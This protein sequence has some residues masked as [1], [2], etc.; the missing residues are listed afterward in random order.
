MVLE[1]STFPES[2]VKGK[3]LL[4]PGCSRSLVDNFA[5]D[6]IIQTLAF[7]SVA[8]LNSNWVEPLVQPQVFPSSDNACEGVT[9]SMELY[10]DA[11][12]EIAVIQIRSNVISRPALAEEIFQFASKFEVSKI[13]IVGSADGCFM[14]GTSLEQDSRLRTT[15]ESDQSI[16]RIDPIDV[17]S[18]GILKSLT[19]KNSNQLAVYSILML[20]SGLGFQETIDRSESLAKQVLVHLGYDRSEL[21][22][23]LSIQQ[24][25]AMP[26]VSTEAE[27]IL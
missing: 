22:V 23:P 8:V 21:K 17:H 2:L 15:L 4:V 20:V 27:R 1:Y 10:T 11:A 26:P 16:E 19:N 13:L 3:T 6:W 25:Q 7:S 9:S 14:S 12:A 5:V 18:G 24:L